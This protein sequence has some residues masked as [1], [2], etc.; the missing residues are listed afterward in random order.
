MDL[1]PADKDSNLQLLPDIIEEVEEYEV[2][3]ILDHKGGKRQQR[4]LIKWKGYPMSEASW[5]SK[6]DL[7]HAP[8]R[9]LEYE[10]SLQGK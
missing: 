8:D 2:E 6:K 7:R 4:Y 10:V 5:E 1:H 3:R 9:V